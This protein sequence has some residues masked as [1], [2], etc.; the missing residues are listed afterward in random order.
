MSADGER[1][2]ESDE[3]SLI[4][5]ESAGSGFGLVALMNLRV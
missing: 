5:K 1:C 2:V 3:R 4:E